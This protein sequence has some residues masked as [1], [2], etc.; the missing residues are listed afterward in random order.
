MMSARSVQIT[1]EQHIDRTCCRNWSGRC[2]S[3]QR[4]AGL[5]V[6]SSGWSRGGTW[7]IIIHLFNHSFDLRSELG[8]LVHFKLSLVTRGCSS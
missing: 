2:G 5:G 8:K 3:I 1:Y 4:S 7:T 6:R